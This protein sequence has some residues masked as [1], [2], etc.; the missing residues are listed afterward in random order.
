M[1]SDAAKRAISRVRQ[2]RPAT[3]SG[4][5]AEIEQRRLTRL[6]R[7]WLD[8]D[9]KR[10][11]FRV[12]AVEDKRSIEIAG[13]I[14]TTRLDR[15]DEIDDGRRII[16]DYKTG[17]Q[18]ASAMLGERPDEPQLPLYLLGAEPAAA[19][20]AFAQ[21]KAGDVRFRALARDSDLLPGVQAFSESRFTREHGSWEQLV[22]AWEAD[23]T[24]IATGFASGDA[25]VDPKRSWQTCS[26]CDLRSFCRINERDEGAIDPLIEC[27]EGGE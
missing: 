27:E 4:R 19:A 10:G 25:R 18:S 15:V 3:L 8:E 14:L 6:A 22:S 9:R 24:R 16:I 21:I 13:L 17:T 20:V 11:D 12:A 5:F 23:L 1:L 7:A 26:N 2:H